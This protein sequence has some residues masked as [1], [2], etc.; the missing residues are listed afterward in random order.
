VPTPDRSIR[1]GTR[2]GSTLNWLTSGLAF[3]AAALALFAV[4]I[5]WRTLRLYDH[6]R[7]S[8]SELKASAIEKAL[9]DS[10][11]S[12]IEVL[13]QINQLEA[14]LPDKIYMQQ[15]QGASNDLGSFPKERELAW[16]GYR[17]F[18]W[19]LLLGAL[20][21]GGLSL[22]AWLTYPDMSDVNSLLGYS[23]TTADYTNTWQE[24]R[25]GWFQQ[26]KDLGQLFVLTPIFPLIGAV[27]G[28]MFGVRKGTEE[29]QDRQR[30]QPNSSGGE[31]PNS[32]G[33]EQRQQPN[34]DSSRLKDFFYHLKAALRAATSR[35]GLEN[36]PN[37]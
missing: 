15:P 8:V 1:T 23:G 24:L 27:I 7:V 25:T 32:S 18:K 36:R 3:V 14:S 5:S 2:G 6:V 30:Q 13:Q 26:V 37:P 34:S 19:L 12:P 4:W 17:I 9:K 16:L 22:Y 31:Q 29:G 35:R 20:L 21:F 11:T 10:H 33:G 28:Y